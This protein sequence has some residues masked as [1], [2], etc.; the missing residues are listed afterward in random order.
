MMGELVDGK[1]LSQDAY[2][3]DDQWPPAQLFGKGAPHHRLDTGG[4]LIVISLL[5]L[6]LWATIWGAIV[7]FSAAP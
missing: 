3:A 1:I 5:S 4:I 6:G 7:L 2:S